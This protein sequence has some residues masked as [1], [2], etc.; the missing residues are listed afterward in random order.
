M[1]QIMALAATEI[2]IC[3]IYV[4]MHFCNRARKDLFDDFLNL[5]HSPLCDWTSLSECKIFKEIYDRL[6]ETLWDFINIR[7]ERLMAA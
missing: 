4:K 6:N 5:F 3:I 7:I 1:N 2:T